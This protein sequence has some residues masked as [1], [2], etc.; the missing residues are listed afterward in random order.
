MARFITDIDYTVLV[1][2]EIKG[3]VVGDYIGKLIRA[4]DMAIAQIKNYLMR[5][6]TE[7]IF[8]SYDPIPDPD[9]RNAH[10][11]MITIDCA[12]YHLYTSTAPDRM[13]EHRA[14]RYGDALDWLKDVATGKIQANLPI[15][16]NTDGQVVS[17]FRLGSKYQP[18]NQKW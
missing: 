13:P 2:N 11:V 1:R 16:T 4:E 7:L 15:A 10:I 8:Q 12:L 6:N 5:Y 17:N 18:S 9:P 3:L 14:Q